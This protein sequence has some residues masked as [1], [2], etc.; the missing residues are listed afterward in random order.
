MLG[1]HQG[2]AWTVGMN[3]LPCTITFSG[4]QTSSLVFARPL[5][6]I[7]EKAMSEDSPNTPDVVRVLRP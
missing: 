2:N 1:V 7:P 6:Y 4:N 5:S 3:Y